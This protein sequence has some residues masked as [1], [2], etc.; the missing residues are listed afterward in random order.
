M[1]VGACMFTPGRP[2]CKVLDLIARGFNNYNQGTELPKA[3]AQLLLSNPT[4][5]PGVRTMD[6]GQGTWQVFYAPHIASISSTFGVTFDTIQYV[7]D[8][9]KLSSNVRYSHPLLGTG[10]LSASG[11]LAAKDD[12]T[13]E[14]HFDKF[15]IDGGADGLRPTLTEGT[16]QPS[17]SMITAVGKAGFLPQ[18][19][20]F[21]VAYLDEDLAVFEF[22]PLK[23]KIAVRR[24]PSPT[25]TDVTTSTI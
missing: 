17:D 18:F 11:G 10:W 21:P 1:D 8:G 15:W 20:V 19:A 9:D 23:S 16:S 4:P 24:L 22:P 7:L 25:V 5:Q 12:D 6:L 3:V 14:L 2:A 13:V